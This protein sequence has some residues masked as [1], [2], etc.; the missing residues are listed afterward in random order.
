MKKVFIDSD[1]IV[2]FF[3][4]RRPFCEYSAKLL[5]LCIEGK[6]KGYV[7]PVVLANLYYVLRKEIDKQLLKDKLLTLLSF[8]DVITM[9]NKVILKALNSDFKDFED[10]LQYFSVVNY[11]DI[12]VILTR[13]VKD[14]KKSSLSVYTPKAYLK[15][16]NF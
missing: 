3:T 7:T 14:Y 10:A 13:N 9:H 4:N 6:L 16:L 15:T 5:N 2:D 11:N 12:Q 1:V 8:L